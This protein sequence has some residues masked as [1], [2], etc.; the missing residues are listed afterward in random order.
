MN[1]NKFPPSAFIL[2][3]QCRPVNSDVRRLHR[4]RGRTGLRRHDAR[5]GAGYLIEVER[6]A[7]DAGDEI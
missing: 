2:A 1:E 7:D 5:D 4:N 6:F 3:F